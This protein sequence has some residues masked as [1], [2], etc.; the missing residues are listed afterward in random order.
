MPICRGL[1]DIRPG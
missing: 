1:D